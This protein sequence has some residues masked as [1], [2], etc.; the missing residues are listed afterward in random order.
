MIPVQEI[1]ACI[2]CFI[3]RFR[4]RYWIVWRSQAITC[5]A[6][7]FV[8]TDLILCLVQFPVY[9]RGEATLFVGDLPPYHTQEDLY[10]TFSHFGPVEHVKL[11]REECY[12][13]IRFDCKATA[14]RVLRSCTE[15]PLVLAGHELRVNESYGT[16]AEWKVPCT[17]LTSLI[18]LD[19]LIS[20]H[21]IYYFSLPKL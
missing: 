7:V 17:L 11:R 5:S 8:C 14:Q 13:F 1:Q 16:L 4:C 20:S 9:Y 18:S 2:V 15:K 21:H 6:R 12:A 3:Q 19:N 10:N